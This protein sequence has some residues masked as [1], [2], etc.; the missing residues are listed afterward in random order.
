MRNVTITP[1]LTTALD[2]AWGAIQ[3]HHPDVPAVVITLG[4][5][6]RARGPLR[7]GHF[8]ENRWRRGEESLHELFVGGEGLARGAHDV[9]GTLLHE[10]A[11]G[12]A[13]T[14]G[15][16]DTSRQG[17][18]H[19]ARYKALA[20]ELGLDVAKTGTIGWSATTVPASTA[21]LYHA[22]LRHLEGALV[23]YRHPEAGNGRGDRAS[24]NNGLAAR[25]ACNRLIRASETV[26]TA[27]PITCGLCDTN[28]EP[29][30]AH[31]GSMQNSATSTSAAGHKPGE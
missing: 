5:G 13:A 10:A 14:R 16:Q 28:F 26:L 3:Q 11:H 21:A 8:A 20:M 24:S 7:L 12:A 31:P 19:N 30:A 4:A 6:S 1:R 15:I 27:G 2:H 23:A 17:R 22:E 9:L 29:A 18:F 25:C